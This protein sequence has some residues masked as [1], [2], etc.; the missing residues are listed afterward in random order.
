MI[1]LNITKKDAKGNNKTLNVQFK[2]EGQDIPTFNNIASSKPKESKKNTPAKKGKI[3]ASTPSNTTQNVATTT[4]NNSTSTTTINTTNNNTKTSTD[5]TINDEKEGGASFGI[6]LILV[7]LYIT[8]WVISLIIFIF[9]YK[10]CYA[11]SNKNKIGAGMNCNFVILVTCFVLS[12]LIALAYLNKNKSDTLKEKSDNMNNAK[13]DMTKKNKVFPNDNEE[14]NNNGSGDNVPNQVDKIANSQSQNYEKNQI[15][16]P[17]E[18]QH[19]IPLSN[20]NKEA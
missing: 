16:D 14:N 6:G 17:N 13:F 10:Q 18:K 4:N 12:P 7:I 8:Q 15:S 11:R 2:L 19:I 5:N 1:P 9:F 20:E 3:P